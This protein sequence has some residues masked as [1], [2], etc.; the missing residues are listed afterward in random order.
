MRGVFAVV[1][2]VVVVAASSVLL[3]STELF[4]LFIIIT[5]TSYVKNAHNDQKVHGCPSTAIIHIKKNKKI[6]NILLERITLID[7]ISIIGS[8]LINYFCYYWIIISIRNV[9]IPNV[10]RNYCS[11]EYHNHNQYSFYHIVYIPINYQLT[12]AF[13]HNKLI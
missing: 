6:V 4:I 8:W 2:Q 3:L 10:S 11:P 12:F 9:I 7:D 5:L 13:L 1:V